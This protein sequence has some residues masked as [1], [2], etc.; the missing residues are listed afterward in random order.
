MKMDIRDIL[1]WLF[2]ALALLIILLRIFGVINTPLYVEYLPAILVVFSA[3]IAYQKLISS[4]DVIG[5][6]TRYLGGKMESVE[7][8]LKD[9][10]NRIVSLEKA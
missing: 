4:V 6:R 1:V 10:D 8:R 7:L 2:L 3:G 9:Y 5:R